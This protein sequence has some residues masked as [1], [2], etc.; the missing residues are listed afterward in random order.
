MSRLSDIL[1]VKEGQEFRFNGDSRYR[2]MGD[3]REYCNCFDGGISGYQQE[4][5]FCS[6]GKRREE[7]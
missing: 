7:E 4:D 2:I 6:Y 5:D 3:R 1:G